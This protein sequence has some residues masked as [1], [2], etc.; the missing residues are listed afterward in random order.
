MNDKNKNRPGYKKT[1]IGWIPEEWEEKRLRDLGNITSGTTPNRSEDKYFIGGKIPW[2]KTTDLNN[3]MINST[4]ECITPY[5]IE[6]RLA[7]ILPKHTLLIA[8]Y[9]G[10]RQIGRTGLLQRESAINQALS[11]LLP[12]D[13]CFNQYVQYFLNNFVGLWRR[14]AASSRNDPNITGDDVKDF[15]IVLPSLPE[16][17]KIAEILSVWD[18]AIANL[19]KLAEAK[20]KLKRILMQ[21]LLAGEIR[22]KGFGKNWQEKELK[23]ILRQEL[24]PVSKPGKAYKSLG[25]R[26]HGKGTF[27]KMVQNPDEVGMDTLYEVKYNQLIVNI[28]FAWEGAIAIV[29]KEDEGCLV[30]HRFP[31]YTI[32]ESQANPEFIRYLILSPKMRYSLGLI[33]PGGAGRN[34][35]LSQ[36][37]FLKLKFLKKRYLI[38]YGMKK[39]EKF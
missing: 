20:K 9:G 36:K 21:R 1:S 27:Q 29:K 32:I 26:S 30:S 6:K 33:S 4:E 38:V 25:I 24:F 8:M 15:K 37:D 17:E 28:T 35:V 2:V 16:Q 12:S 19:A 11:A 34:R 5:A 10:Y 18:E 39:L 22:F 13:K 14:Y 31:T 7:K 3:Y 23:T